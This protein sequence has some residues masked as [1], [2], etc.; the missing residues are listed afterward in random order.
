MVTI[1]WGESEINGIR[2]GGFVVDAETVGDAIALYERLSVD[3]E[4]FGEPQ[5]DPPRTE[6]V[7][8]CTPDEFLAHAVKLGMPLQDA[9]TALS[10]ASKG[11]VDRLNIMGKQFRVM[12]D[13]E[14]PGPP[15][16]SFRF[17]KT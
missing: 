3:C 13:S 7:T 10:T 9:K 15:V 1:R 16:E 5:K 14:R 2:T 4:P 12:P 6:A 8:A 11:G 17:G